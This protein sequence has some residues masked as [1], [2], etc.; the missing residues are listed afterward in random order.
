AMALAYARLARDDAQGTPP[1]ARITAAI[2]A[3]PFL[4]GGTD[5]FDTILAEETGGAILAKVGAEG[6][7]C[8][9]IPAS[10][11]GVAIK[12]EDGAQRAQHAAL[13]ATLS[14][15][16]LLPDP[17]PPRLADFARRPVRNTRGDAVGELAAGG[18]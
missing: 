4:V 5:R 15:L 12:V 11:L 7:H 8:A 2:R 6:V 18:A 16:G 14:Q 17:L 10:G 1:A 13:L 3:R 9:M